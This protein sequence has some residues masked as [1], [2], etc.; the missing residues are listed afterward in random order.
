M[1][2]DFA[3]N[4]SGS[5]VFHKSVNTLSNVFYDDADTMSNVFSKEVD[6]MSNA[7]NAKVDRTSKLYC[8]LRTP[9]KELPIFV[10]HYNNNSSNNN[11]NSSN[12]NN[13][14]NNN[15]NNSSS[16]SSSNINNNEKEKQDGISSDK[17][18]E[19]SSISEKSASH[20]LTFEKNSSF[21]IKEETKEMTN[22]L[23]G[24]VQ[25]NQIHDFYKCQDKLGKSQ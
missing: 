1:I 18:S 9:T 11:N 23:Q 22:H 21:Q 7:F 19:K 20:L 8:L 3:T 14:N 25:Q 5:R 24:V 12:N 10:L 13:N 16:S 6:T 4:D 15:S 17:F 2:E